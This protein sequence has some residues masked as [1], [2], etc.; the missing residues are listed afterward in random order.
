MSWK[1]KMKEWGGG[2]L[3]FLSEDGET[4]R[5]IVVG[6]P[7]LLEGEYKGTQTRKIGC[8]VVTEDGFLLFVC[9]MRLARKI[10]KKESQFDKAVFEAQRHGEVGDANATYSLKLLDDSQL[11]TQLLE[12]KKT[13]FKPAMIKE[14][15]EAAKDVMKK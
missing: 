3:T 1:D 7:T 5:F 15:V 9:G 11:F 12:V 8:P 4:I 2:D 13:E 6:E 14:A 10:C